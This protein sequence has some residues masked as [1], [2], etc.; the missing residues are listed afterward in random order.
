M[1]PIMIQPYSYKNKMKCV[2]FY[3]VMSNHRMHASLTSVREIIVLY[4]CRQ[5]HLSVFN[6]Y[7]CSYC[8]KEITEGYS[9]SRWSSHYM[10]KKC[11]QS[12]GWARRKKY[13]KYNFLLFLA[14]ELCIILQNNK[15]RRKYVG[16]FSPQENLTKINVNAWNAEGLSNAE[17]QMRQFSFI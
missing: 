1:G 13:S 15:D 9:K 14:R 12:R 8:Q 6:V 16:Y 10:G 11:T 3:S 4:M 17:R 2:S 5:T 7:T